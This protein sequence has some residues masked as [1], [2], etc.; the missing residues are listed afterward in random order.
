[1]RLSYQEENLSS[2]SFY[3]DCL[4][5]IG[6]SEAVGPSLC[7]SILCAGVSSYQI[8]SRPIG[9]CSPLLFPY[10]K[11]AQHKVV[12]DVRGS[13]SWEAHA[14]FPA[15]ESEEVPP[16]TPWSGEHQGDYVYCLQTS[17]P[18]ERPWHDYL[19]LSLQRSQETLGI[20]R[21][22]VRSNVSCL[23]RTHWGRNLVS[24]LLHGDINCPSL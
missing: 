7:I 14:H 10:P 24:A 3:L 12:E 15:S 18:P 9:S 16:H 13:H 22:F 21:I 11:K 8:L 4:A 20:P 19:L 17:R 2:A 5:K 23:F 1:M 6:F